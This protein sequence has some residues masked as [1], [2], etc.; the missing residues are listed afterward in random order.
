LAR[1]ETIG[2][3]EILREIGRGA[4]GV[5]YEARDP[6]LGRTVALKVI[7][8]AAEG[9]ELQGFEERFLDEAKIAA[10]LQ[11]PGIVVVHEVGRDIGTGTLFIALE[12]LRGETLA[13]LARAG[14][15]R[16][17]RVM[18]IIAQVA[19]ALHH[20]HVQGVV[21]RDIK[22]A[23]VIVLATGEA[24]VTDFGIARFESI[25]GRLTS[26]GQF[27]GTPLYTAPE[28]AR[29]E[30]VDGRADVFSLASVAYTLLT[31]RPPFD[32]PTIPG[33]VHR[34]V[35]EEPV[36]PSR[37]VPEL[38][39]DV[40]RILARALAKDPDHRYPSAEAFAEDAE[41]VAAGAPPRHAAGD[42]L[43]VV[44]DP[45]S[46]HA[47]GMP[48]VF[49]R[50]EAAAPVAPAAP[51]TPALGGLPPGAGD[52]RTSSPPPRRHASRAPVVAAAAAILGVVALFLWAPRQ[53][54]S[55]PGATPPTPAT[56]APSTGP[57]TAPATAP[58]AAPVQTE[59][60]RLRIDFAHPLRRGRLQVF[61][62]DE[63]T[64]DERLTGQQKKTALV[65]KLHEGSLREE[66]DVAPG[67]HE[68]RIEVTWDDNKKVERIVGSFRAGATRRLEASLGRMR[69]DLTLEWH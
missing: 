36:A 21:H 12:L 57:A 51:S 45:A 53:P 30:E 26:T 32:A 47:A 67:L 43:V 13:E 27:I 34:V 66:L 41:D 15:V 20:A 62:D 1:P 60:A 22:P 54:P 4:M 25:R 14:P 64:L 61:V 33:I 7:Q 16:W 42:D 11:H 59:P 55:A 44:D 19:R 49:A 3:F 68:V 50:G 63:L 46:S 39:P 37:L 6:D 9:D 29:V 5:V 31:G 23:N 65:F 35:Y 58:A 56:T 8:A 2:R 69:R 38:P 10:A 18:R 28:Q 40:E 48:A 52:T 24:K 17:E